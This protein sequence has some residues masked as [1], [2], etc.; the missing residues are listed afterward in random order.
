MYP[1]HRSTLCLSPL[2]PLPGLFCISL[3]YRQSAQALHLVQQSAGFCIR[4]LHN[5]G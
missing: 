1:K 4:L 2:Q 5:N 3:L